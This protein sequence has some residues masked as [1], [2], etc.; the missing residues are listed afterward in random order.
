MHSSKMCLPTCASTCQTNFFKWMPSTQQTP[1]EKA[2]AGGA[3][4]RERIVQK[5]DIDVL[6]HRPRQ[7]HPL[8]L[9]AAEIDPTLA[10]LGRVPRRQDVQVVLQRAG[11]NHLVVPVLVVRS[12]EGDIVAQRAVHDEGGLGGVGD[13][14]VD[15]DL[16]LELDQLAEHRVQQRGLARADL[17]DDHAEG[18]AADLQID[19]GQHM[20]ALLL[21]RAVGDEAVGLLLRR[22]LLAAHPEAGLEAIK[23]AGL[24]A[25]AL[26]VVPRGVEGGRR[27]LER[28]AVDLDRAVDRGTVLLHV[29]LDAG[30]EA[31]ALATADVQVDE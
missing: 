7:R 2:D 25:V 8:L 12:A 27:P 6:I 16:P 30:G 21:H 24:L 11:I 29:L 5:V 26:A 18:S 10:D 15:P 3:H 19:L 14:A 31:L 20:H 28:A 13:G 23:D 17:P 22:A 4:G 1:A 9:A